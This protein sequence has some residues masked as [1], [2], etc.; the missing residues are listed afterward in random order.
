MWCKE[1]K[2]TS[3]GWMFGSDKEQEGHLWVEVA[4]AKEKLLGVFVAGK[5]EECKMDTVG[6]EINDY[7][8]K[9]LGKM[10]DG[11]QGVEEEAASERSIS[12]SCL[13]MSRGN[14][15]GRTSGRSVNVVV[16]GLW[17]PPCCSWSQ[18]ERHIVHSSLHESDRGLNQQKHLL[19]GSLVGGINLLMF[20]RDG[21]ICLRPWI[22]YVIVLLFDLDVNKFQ[23]IFS[24]ILLQEALYYKRTRITESVLVLL[25]SCGFPYIPPPFQNSS[26]FPFVYSSLFPWLLYNCLS[27][28]EEVFLFQK[29]TFPPTCL[30]VWVEYFLLCK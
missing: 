3:T 1:V 28:L 20:D 19:R 11:I 30:S 17:L 8:N 9:I 22:I 18:G 4:W 6:W 21:G 15:V 5:C 23:N 27:S 7:K 12:F 24:P 25:A 16:G 13:V 14:S 29:S 10:I 26:K 2:I